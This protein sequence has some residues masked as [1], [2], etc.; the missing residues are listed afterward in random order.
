MLLDVVVAAAA[1]AVAHSALG[2]MA[3]TL[4]ALEDVHTLFL[5]SPAADTPRGPGLH[6]L[7]NPA[8]AD[9]DAGVSVSV[10]AAAER[11]GLGTG[12]LGLARW[13]TLGLVAAVVAAAVA[14]AVAVA[15]EAGRN[16]HM[17]VAAVVVA[18]AEGVAHR[19]M[20]DSR[21]VQG[22]AEVVGHGA[23]AVHVGE[24]EAAGIGAVRAV[25]G[26]G[27]AT[28]GGAHMDRRIRPAVAAGA[29]HPIAAAELGTVHRGV[30]VAAEAEGECDRAVVAAAVGQEANAVVAA[31][32]G[33][34]A[35]AAVAVE[36]GEVVYVHEEV[37]AAAAVEA[38]A[39]VYVHAAAELVVAVYARAAVEEAA[40]EYVHVAVAAGEAAGYAMEVA[41]IP[42]V[43][44]RAVGA[45]VEH[46]PAVEVV[47]EVEVVA[48]TAGRTDDIPHL[49]HH[50]RRG[51]QRP[52]CP[53]QHR[54][55]CCDFPGLVRVE[56][57]L[58]VCAGS[59]QELG[60]GGWFGPGQMRQRMLGAT[61]VDLH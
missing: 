32:V 44:A 31:A 43:V 12:Q 38:R 47:V 24:V 17:Q 51:R 1:A 11:V 41:R 55:V 45:V 25:E 56:G 29:G 10:W 26:V 2:D 54:Q 42:G 37:G 7:H 39:V 8:E 49:Y 57:E 23:D 52:Q 60:V 59:S 14:V 46:I 53:L 61:G 40:A 36:A 50:T 19:L 13:N 35:N 27:G 30:A 5:D 3:D 48:V 28:G 33:E 18:A 20:Q 16:T 15:A 22:E 58:L 34:E 6:S 9:D 21:T 4:P